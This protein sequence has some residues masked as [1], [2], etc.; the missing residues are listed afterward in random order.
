ME[1]GIRL[2]QAL[3]GYTTGFSIP[4]FVLDTPYGKIPMTPNTIVDRDDDAVYLRSWDGK[5]WR[6]PNSRDGQTEVTDGILGRS[7]DK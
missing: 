7:G 4:T 3:R 6:E 2:L 1:T 5:V